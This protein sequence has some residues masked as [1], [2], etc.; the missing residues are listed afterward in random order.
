[1]RGLVE[2]TLDPKDARRYLYRPSFELLSYLGIK[3]IEEL[4]DYGEINKTILN[5]EE[6]MAEENERG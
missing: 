5:A 2:R 6:K 3:S 4:P 1:V